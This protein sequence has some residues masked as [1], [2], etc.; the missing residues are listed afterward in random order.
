MVFAIVTDEQSSRFQQQ[1]FC[2]RQTAF[3]SGLFLARHDP[4]GQRLQHVRQ[5]NVVRVG[6]THDGD[7]PAQKRLSLFK[8]LSQTKIDSKALALL[9]DAVRRGL[10]DT[11]RAIGE[12]VCG[13][14]LF[15]RGFDR[16]RRRC[17]E[18]R[19]AL[20]ARPQ[21]RVNA[22]GGVVNRLAHCHIY[23]PLPRP[24]QFG[25]AYS[26]KLCMKRLVRSAFC[27]SACARSVSSSA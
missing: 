3:V 10:D 23:L 1:A 9:S 21:F 22:R 18:D 14:A 15:R 4:P 20:P 17:S 8:R 11:N 7:A 16:L 27:F 25:L 24:Y 19:R 12:S 26:R 6:L 13:R 2:L 5:V